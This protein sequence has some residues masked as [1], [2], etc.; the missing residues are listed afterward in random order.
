MTERE[1]ERVLR[2]TFRDHE[3]AVNGLRDGLLPAARTR[4]RRF[5]RLRAGGAGLAVA[6]V[7]GLTIGLV[8]ALGGPAGRRPVDTRQDTGPAG[9]NPGGL[10]QDWVWVSSLGLEIGVPGGWAVNDYGCHMTNRPS[11]VRGRGAE[12]DC[13]TPEPATKQVAI[14]AAAPDRSYDAGFSRRAVTID[15]EAGTRAEGRLPD[16]RH[17][18]QLAI[19]GR[20]IYLD[21]R[22]IDEVELTT[23][24]DSARLVDFDRVG[25]PT[26]RQPVAVGAPA[27]ASLAPANPLWAR[28]CYY[29]SAGDG[30]LQASTALS[31]AE[32]AALVAAMNA[33]PPGRNP[34]LRAPS[35]IDPPPPAPDVVLHLVSTGGVRVVWVTFSPCTG[36]GLDN[37]V[38]QAYIDPTMIAL[39]MNPLH[40]G[41]A[42]NADLGPTTK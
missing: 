36:R 5:Q 15:G 4:S 34:D 14:I 3:H 11:V 1:L 2:D 8:T 32:A 33:A 31:H 6:A 26:R 29:G 21:V 10:P 38:R 35:C 7:V 22:T 41:Y 18:G 42:F 24:L 23:I 12:E 16:G 28:D 39:I 37:G 40:S 13:Y 19:P 30:R 25:C 17:A 20:D 27:D 9:V